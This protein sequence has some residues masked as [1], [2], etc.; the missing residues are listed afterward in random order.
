[1]NYTK[2][3]NRVYVSGYIYTQNTGSSTSGVYIV[4]RDN[5]NTSNV[6]TLPY[7][8]NH[9][10]G[11]PVTGTRTISDLY[12]NMAVTFQENSST[13]YLYKDDGDNNYVKNTNNVLVGS[14]V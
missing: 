3:G 11:L 5:S 8:P 9:S 14:K 13:V 6:A 7:L 2:I 10:G 12:R 4:L 1:M